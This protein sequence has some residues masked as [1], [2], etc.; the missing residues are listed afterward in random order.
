MVFELMNQTLLEM[1][2]GSAEGKL[3]REQ[4]RLIVYQMVKALAFMHARNVR[5]CIIYINIDCAQRYKAR[6][7]AFV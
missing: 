4:V 1:L 3:E 5:I 6:K 7:Y 2:Q